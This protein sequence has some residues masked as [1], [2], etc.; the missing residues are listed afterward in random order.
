MLR[1]VAEVI[2][3]QRQPVIPDRLHN[4]VVYLRQCI[5][6]RS[7]GMTVKFATDPAW[8]VQQA[9][10]RRAGWP[11]DPGCYRGSAMPING[12]Y[13]AKAQG[14]VYKHLELLAHGINRPRV[15]VR[16]SW[17]GEWRSYL[18]ARIPHRITRQGEE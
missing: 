9:I 14:E 18:L 15:I 2:S 5:L 4:T 8:L 10:N 3:E 1:A 16:E 12:R 7:L 13:P 11:D 17:L 6:A